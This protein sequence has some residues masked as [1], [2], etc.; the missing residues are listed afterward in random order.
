MGQAQKVFRIPRLER[1]IGLQSRHLLRGAIPPYR[2]RKARGTTTVRAGGVLWCASGV[3][4][5]SREVKA[6]AVP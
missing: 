2:S 4:V 1:A 5:N 6:R 3:A